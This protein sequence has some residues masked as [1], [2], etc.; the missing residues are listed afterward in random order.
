MKTQER[1]SILDDVNEDTAVAEY[2][3]LEL[4]EATPAPRTR[5]PAPYS[6]PVPDPAYERALSH[7]AAVLSDRTVVSLILDLARA[8][9]RTR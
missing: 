4:G 7:V 2:S 3:D 5:T 9:E 6:E 8:R 1:P